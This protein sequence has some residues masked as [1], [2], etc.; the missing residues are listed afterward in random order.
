V[1]CGG[2]W[3]EQQQKQIPFGDDRKKSKSNCNDKSKFGCLSTPVEMT[4]FV[5]AWIVGY[6]LCGV[7]L[8]SEGV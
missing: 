4:G 5:G 1:D 3:Q 8:E 7:S 2:E 6:E